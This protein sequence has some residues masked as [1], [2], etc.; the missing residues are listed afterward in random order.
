MAALREGLEAHGLPSL[1]GQYETAYGLTEPVRIEQGLGQGSL[2]SPVRAKLMLSVI[3]HALRKLCPGSKMTMDGR[4]IVELWYADDGCICTDDLPSL[5]LAFECVWLTTKMLGLLWQVKGKKKTAWSATWWKDGTEVDVTGYEMCMP[6]GSTVPQ[7]VGDDIYKYLGTEMNTG[8]RHGNAHKPAR[9]KVVARCRQLIGLLGRVPC[10][11][12]QQYG[13]AVSLAL[14]GCIGYYARS[15]VLTWEDCVTIEQARVAALQAKGVTEGVPRR[16]IFGSPEHAEMGHEH[17]YVIAAAALRD[18]IDR[19]L[20]GREGEPARAVVEEAIA[21]TCYRLGCRGTHP[22]EWQPTHLVHELRDD[23]IIEAYLK[24]MIQCGWR[25]HLTRGGEQLHGP[26][27]TEAEWEWSDDKAHGYGPMLWEGKQRGAWDSRDTVCTYSRALARKGITHWAHITSASGGVWLTTREAKTLYNLRP[28]REVDDYERVVALLDSA[29][30]RLQRDRWFTMVHAGDVHACDLDPHD[31]GGAPAESRDERLRTGY[32]ELDKVVAARRTA[33]CFGGYEYAVK[34]AGAHDVSWVPQCDMRGDQDTRAAMAA[35]REHSLKAASYLEWLDTTRQTAKVKDTK[36][37]CAGDVNRHGWKGVWRL[38]L[39]YREAS[40]VRGCGVHSRSADN[41]TEAPASCGRRG[42]QWQADAFST[43]FL[44]GGGAQAKRCSLHTSTPVAPHLHVT[45]DIIANRHA[46][47][48]GHMRTRIAQH[49]VD[50]PPVSATCLHITEI[51]RILRARSAFGILG[52]PADAG[53]NNVKLGVWHTS[54]LGRLN[55]A[56]EAAPGTRAAAEAKLESARATLM[57]PVQ[58]QRA[59]DTYRH[60][61]DETTCTIRCPIDVAALDT[62]AHSPAAD[63]VYDGITYRA[64]IRTYLGA[65]SMGGDGTS[66]HVEIRYRHTDLAQALV[67]AGMIAVSRSYARAEDWHKDPFNLPKVLRKLALARFGSDFDDEA[68]HPRAHLSLVPAGR[69]QAA[70][71]LAHREEILRKTGAILF[72]RATD[73]AKRQSAKAAFSSFSMDGSWQQ[74]LRRTY[75]P[76]Q[77]IPVTRPSDLTFAVCGRPGLFAGDAPTR[78]FNLQ[79]YLQSQH[80]ST[81]WLN[82]KLETSIG[83]H[84]LVRAW[85]DLHR[86][87]KRHPER[88]LK[89]YAYQEL[90]SIS[91][92]AKEAW[93]ERN[94]HAAISLQ[95]DGVVVA[96]RGEVNAGT[97]RLE[98][99]RASERALTYPQPVEIKPMKDASGVTITPQ[100]IEDT[101]AQL[102]YVGR[103]AHSPPRAPR[104][105]ELSEG[106]SACGIHTRVAWDEAMLTFDRA[107]L[108]RG[109]AYD[110]ARDRQ[111]QADPVT[112]LF[113]RSQRLEQGDSVSTS[114]GTPL[115]MDHKERKLQTEGDASVKASAHTLRTLMRLHVAHQFTHA[116]AV[117][118]S[119][120]GSEP[121]EIAPGRSATGRGEDQYSRED[122]LARTAYGVWEGLGPL[123]RA[124]PG[125]PAVDASDALVDRRFAASLWGGRLPD[126]FAIVDAEMYACYRYLLKVWTDAAT[127]AA[128]AACRVLICSDC[129]P[130]LQ[131]IEHAWRQNHATGFRRY[132]RGHLL[133]AICNL[134]ADMGRVITVWTPAHV[135]ITPNAMADCAAKHHTRDTHKEDTEAQIAPHVLARPCTYARRIH[136]RLGDSVEAVWE[137]A[138]RRPYAETKRRARIYVRGKLSVG[139]KDG[140]TTAGVAGR[141][142]SDVVKRVDV[143]LH[144]DMRK[145]SGAIGAP[146]A[147]AADDE[148]RGR[149]KLQPEDV[150]HHNTRRAIVLGMRV[151]NVLGVSHGRG[152]ARRRRGE[153][154]RGG[155]ATTSE[156]WG[157]WG[158]KRARDLK[159]RQNEQQ[160]PTVKTR[161]QQQDAWSTEAQQQLGTKATLQ[162]VLCGEC[163]GLPMRESPESRFA[164]DTLD[165]A[166]H[167]CGARKSAQQAS[168]NGDRVAATLRGA[169][170]AAQRTRTQRPVSQAQWQNRWAVLAGVLPAWAEDGTEAREG[171]EQECAAALNAGVDLAVHTLAQWQQCAKAGSTFAKHREQHRGLLHLVL[172]AWREHVEHAAPQLQATPA[173]WRVRVLPRH[174]LVALPPAQP[175]DAVQGAWP[176]AGD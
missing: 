48:W 119:K 127:P 168:T 159:A 102:A 125:T 100:P 124:T 156:V 133:E 64:R 116:A 83:A 130:A 46:A 162:H 19:A 80:D 104:A 28:G 153:A 16:Q 123:G 38:F 107:P 158:C 17:A 56:P 154:H 73:E 44:G 144:S 172:R 42:R 122:R 58:R 89:S 90:E 9:A 81:A 31:E 93:C 77:V 113:L 2:L 121:A 149:D 112:R 111:L 160:A 79:L 68:A 105:G 41:H 157:C 131:Q 85:L 148:E 169:Q 1:T 63:E 115:T 8:W 155:P 69:D 74:F 78:T 22:L 139:L 136:E 176:S 91:R 71:F 132:D 161:A 103:V 43:C 18:Q 86:P 47:E 175:S 65:V 34:W 37:T 61:V 97:A 135:G 23:L 15:T 114:A 26:L 109:R 67:D 60:Q 70:F 7:L 10:L 145:Q 84:S 143:K 137:H 36:A 96:L 106:I 118:G 76:C 110:L 87:H 33:T 147:D 49:P 82:D 151:D 50:P 29:H 20:C 53:T 95:H 170:Q 126:S 128:R 173:A 165:K 21:K 164:R 25:G 140:C 51:D 54:A 59:L 120:E 13:C 14:S 98:L 62:F 57:D 174:S 5:Q 108:W 4:R 24:G 138:D 6:D 35:A 142:W 45:D 166:V 32:W 163:E 167:A 75:A 99:Q 171:P 66:G 152:W 88:T 52:A 92:R 3:Q 72:P 129:R 30:N 150:R 134:R 101:D 94:G 55:A 27:G 12:E 11:T 146:V 40:E 117:D 141:L 39:Q